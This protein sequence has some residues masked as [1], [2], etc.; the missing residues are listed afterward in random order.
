MTEFEN[1]IVV[2]GGAGHVGLPLSIVLA[3]RGHRVVVYDLDQKAVDMVIRGE[4]P[5][6]EPGAEPVLAGSLASG[7]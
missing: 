7:L 4:L 5:F 3:S 6:L 2:I 1:D